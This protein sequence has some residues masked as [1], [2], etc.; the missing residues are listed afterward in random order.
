MPLQFDGYSCYWFYYTNFKQFW[1]YFWVFPKSIFC[2]VKAF[3]ILTLIYEFFKFFSFKKKLISTVQI[4]TLFSYAVW[5]ALWAA[6]RQVQ[7]VSLTR[8]AQQQPPSQLP[9][10]RWPNRPR[11]SRVSLY[12]PNQCRH[13]LIRSVT[14]VMVSSCK[15]K[16]PKD[17]RP[18]SCGWHYLSHANRWVVLCLKKM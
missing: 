17:L 2:Y 6:Q 11:W 10:R 5:T 18:S 4:I 16:P 15:Q 8:M 13:P 9:H 14:S 12:K 3:K 7:R 1:V